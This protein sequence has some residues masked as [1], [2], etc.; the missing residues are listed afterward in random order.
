[1]NKQQV[2][3]ALSLRARSLDIPTESHPDRLPFTGVLTMIDEPSDAA[4]EGSNGRRILLT[5]AA[6]KAALDSLLGQGIN[7]NLEGHSPREKI[8]V[9]YGSEIVGNEI[10]ISGTIYAA[11]SP[12]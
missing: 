9:I 12:R 1:M 8:G 5:M 2:F 7:F 10:R 11:T 4:P 6:A 3:P